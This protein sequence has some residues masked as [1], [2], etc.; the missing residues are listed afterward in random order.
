MFTLLGDANLDGTVNA[1]DYT[2]FSHNVGQSGMMWDDGDF[3]YDGT[4]NAEDYTL[5]AHNLGQSAVLASPG[6][7]IN[8]GADLE[9]NST[10]LTIASVPDPASLCLLLLGAAGFLAR[11]RR[12]VRG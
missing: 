12:I 5:F 9:I 1:E 8:N 7:M 3:N 4:V 2:A 6:D 11:R 10:S